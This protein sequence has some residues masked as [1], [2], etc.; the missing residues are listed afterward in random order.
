[1]RDDSRARPEVLRLVA[2]ENGYAA[3]RLAPLARLAG[4]LADEM[5]APLPSV[6]RR[7]PAV[8]GAFEYV[9]RRGPEDDHWDVYRRPAGGGGGVASA[10][11]PPAAAGA[12]SR[13]QQVEDND[14]GWQLAGPFNRLSQGH[15]YFDVAHW[16]ASPDSSFL[17]FAV[18]TRGD[19]EF[20][21]YALRLPLGGGSSGISS[22]RG[23]SSRDRDE[24]DDHWRGPA[25]PALIARGAAGGGQLVWA[26]D[27][28]HLFVLDQPGSNEKQGGSETRVVRRPVGAAG[29]GGGEASGEDSGSGAGPAAGAVLLRLPP[30]ALDLELAAGSS[31]AF[32]MLRYSDEVRETVG[33]GAT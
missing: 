17:A 13:H 12:T 30:G 6:E 22:S 3:A 11:S 27:S 23:G 26:P 2:A 9:E 7:A 16:A 1:M 32:L 8:S 28:R 4:A 19:E 29:S 18:D 10:A 20:T 24:S 15:S 21:V 5:D 31:G 33:S 14:A 25:A